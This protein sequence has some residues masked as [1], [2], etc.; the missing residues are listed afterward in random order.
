MSMASSSHLALPVRVE[1]ATRLGLITENERIRVNKDY[2]T[3]I[4][5]LFA[6]GDMIGGDDCKSPKAVCDGMNAADAIIRY[7]R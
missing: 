6:A 7:L 2:P 4:D 5:G 1:F 3:N